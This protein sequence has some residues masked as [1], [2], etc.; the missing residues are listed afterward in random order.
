MQQ[1]LLDSDYICKTNE[2]NPEKH[3]TKTK[4]QNKLV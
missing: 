3:Q 1:Y 4:Q 2:Q